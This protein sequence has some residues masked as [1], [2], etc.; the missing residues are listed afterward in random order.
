MEMVGE[1]Y[2][3]V[4]VVRWVLNE[5]EVGVYYEVITVGKH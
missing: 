1:G 4:L 2:R 3:E 5:E